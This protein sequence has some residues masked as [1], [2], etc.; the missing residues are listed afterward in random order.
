MVMSLEHKTLDYRNASGKVGSVFS[1][2]TL[3]N[4][5]YPQEN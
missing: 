3:S 1:A 5:S 2:K 4:K